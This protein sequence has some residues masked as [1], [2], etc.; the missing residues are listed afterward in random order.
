MESVQTASKIDT[1]VGSFLGPSVNA[2]SRMLKCSA[3]PG[4]KANAAVNYR[5]VGNVRGRKLL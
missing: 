4:N 3:E 1:A 2:V 5:I